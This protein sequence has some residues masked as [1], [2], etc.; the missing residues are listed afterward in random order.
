M[1]PSAAAQHRSKHFEQLLARELAYIERGHE[2]NLLTY[3]KLER[4]ILHERHRTLNVKRKKSS[5]DENSSK[6]SEISRS[7]LISTARPHNPSLTNEKLPQINP[8]YH[9]QCYKSQRLP[10]IVKLK[11]TKNDLHWIASIKSTNIE[12]ETFSLLTEEIPKSLPELTPIEKKIH[13]FMESLPANKG[14]Q[15]GFDNFA[16]AAIYSVRSPIAMR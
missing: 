11:R 4:S 16:P 10:P 1:I 9:R 15:K 14:V 12:N 13:S 7:S 5:I 8:K 3:E 6:Q 2:L